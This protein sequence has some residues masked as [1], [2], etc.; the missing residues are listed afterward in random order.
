M[1][2][3]ERQ[4]TM[5]KEIAFLVALMK[6]VIS[7]LIHLI[8]SILYDIFSLSN[9]IVR[10]V[11]FRDKTN[12]D[13]RALR[14]RILWRRKL[15]EFDSSSERDFLCIYSS[16]INSEFVLKPNVSLYSLNKHAAIFIETAEHINIYNSD[17]N[18]FLCFAQFERSKYVITMPIN[19]FHALADK[20]GRVA[21]PVVWL[22]Q[23]GRCGSTILCQVLENVSGTLIMSEPDAPAN[24]DLMQQRRE[25]T[26]DERDRLL[27]SA[28]KLL[29]K[30]Y[31]GARMICIK[32]KNHCIS[33]MKHL[34]RLFPSMKQIFIYRNCRETVASLL[35]LQTA[36]A[37][38]KVSKVLIDSKWLTGLKPF[39]KAQSEIIFIRKTKTSEAINGLSKVTNSVGLFTYMWANY[40]LVALDAMSQDEN[41]LTVKYEDLVSAKSETCSLIF[42][43]LGIDACHLA[44]AITAFNRDSQRGS[45]L[46][47]SRIGKPS[48]KLI[49]N[50]EMVEADV[51]LSCYNLPRMGEDFTL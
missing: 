1:F 50:Q 26:E 37:Y 3:K 4:D 20:I 22:S 5:E 19:S 28:T 13:S 38:T 44:T 10:S 42:R 6:F 12:D 23:T 32:T 30:P 34:S 7:I 48:N 35:S 39:F 25:I 8:F 45:I 49:S 31:P 16:W 2:Q 46:S 41:I 27:V 47:I 24:I 18:P 21:M 9:T 15:Y 11:F 14:G 40:M 33:L 17:T 51:I 43:N 36:T 29:C